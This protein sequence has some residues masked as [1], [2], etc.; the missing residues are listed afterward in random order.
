MARGDVDDDVEVALGELLDARA[1]QLGAVVERRP[2]GGVE[3]DAGHAVRHDDAPQDLAV[4]G[5]DVEDARAGAERERA[6][7]LVDLRLAER[8]GEGQPGVRDRGELVAVHA[9][10][11]AAAGRSGAPS[12]KP[13][14]RR[15]PSSSSAASWSGV[16]TPSA[17]VSS[18]SAWASAT[19]AASTPA[20]P[21]TS[22]RSSLT[23]SMGQSRRWASEAV[24]APKSSRASSTPRSDSA[25]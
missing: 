25:H 15:Q 9:A 1:A 13:C 22:A 14:A 12:R 3:P 7:Q 16:S 4:A 19:T 10:C 2:G 18:P 17:T 6:D 5:A 23:S 24:P 8:V 11:S 20:S 21:V